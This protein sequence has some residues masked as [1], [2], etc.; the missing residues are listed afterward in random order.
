MKKSLTIVLIILL[1]QGIQAQD[2]AIET[3]V[4]YLLYAPDSRGTALGTIG[5]ASQADA[6][7]MHWNP[8]KYAFSDN[9]FGVAVSYTPW[10]WLLIKDYDP[11]DLSFGYHAFNL[12]FKIKDKMAISTSMVYYSIG[13]VT[14]TN[15]YGEDMGTYVPYD[16]YNDVS[17]SYRIS[18]ALSLGLASRLIYSDLTRG[19]FIQ[20]S[21]TSA[22]ISV[23]MDI[24]AYYEK[25][26]S[27][28]SH[29]GTIAWGVNISNIGTKMAYTETAFLEDFIPTNLRAGIGLTTRFNPSNSLT[30][31][32]DFNK[33]LVP[34]PPV[35]L[36]DSLGNPVY[37]D[38]HNP[39]IA[40]GMD[41]NVSVLK[42]MFQSWYDAPGGFEEE[43]REWSFGIGAEYWYKSIFSAR[44][45]I[46][47]EDKTKGTRRYFTTGI[48]IRYKYFGFD[49]GILIPFEENNFN[50]FN[51]R[52]SII[53][54]LGSGERK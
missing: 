36:R 9:R 21:E 3:A 23:A 31:L 2:R 51:I 52:S 11:L 5:A 4:P 26:I 42:G 32:A 44:A 7:A 8:A 1:F 49:T 22:G 45:G 20:G 18:D 48:G 41:P 50:A 43:M 27:L 47:H 38:D 16:F 19:Q 14:F 37:D 13:G 12:Y 10:Y 39:V 25:S 17:F 24:A 54:E 33:L 53:F 46:Y 34:T 29:E 40:E 30:I 28:G 6:F 35:Y 15:E